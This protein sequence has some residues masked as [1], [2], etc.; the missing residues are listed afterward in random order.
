MFYQV[1]GAAFS[2]LINLFGVVLLAVYPV[3]RRAKCQAVVTQRARVQLWN[4]IY[5]T[6][7]PSRLPPERRTQSDG[8]RALVAVVW[9]VV[10]GVGGVIGSQILRA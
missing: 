7:H 1:T 2:W 5:T 10:C 9:V 3:A 6:P 8:I 4:P